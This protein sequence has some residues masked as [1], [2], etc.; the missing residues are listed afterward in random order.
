MFVDYNGVKKERHFYASNNRGRKTKCR[1]SYTKS[2]FI[3]THLHT[4]THTENKNSRR[5]KLNMSKLQ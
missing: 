1:M 5:E 4:Y 2:R 3:H